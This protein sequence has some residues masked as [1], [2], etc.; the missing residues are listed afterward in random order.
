MSERTPIVYHPSEFI[1]EEMQER[2]WNLGDLFYHAGCETEVDEAALELYINP[3]LS[4]YAPG[5]LLGDCGVYLARAFHTSVEFWVNL[6]TAW[7]TWQ[8]VSEV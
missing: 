7:R 1:R 4:G 3:D 6:D 5:I 2:G 8:G